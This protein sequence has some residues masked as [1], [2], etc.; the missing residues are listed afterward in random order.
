[1]S[2]APSTPEHVRSDVRRRR[3]Q[4]GQGLVEYELLIALGALLVI[5]A[6]LF[7]AGKVDGVVRGAGESTSQP[8]FTPP[9]TVQCDGSYQDV[10]I[11]PAPPDLDCGDLVDMGIPLPVRLVGGNDP[12]HLDPDGDGFG[13]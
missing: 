3:A 9:A 13:C 1:M 5:I 2:A 6:M 10:C 4:A 12:H 7:L 11:P 8:V